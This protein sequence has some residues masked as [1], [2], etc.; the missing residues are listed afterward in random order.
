MLILRVPLTGNTN[1][2][3]GLRSAF[4]LFDNAKRVV[5]TQVILIVTDGK[6]TQGNP[7]YNANLPGAV[8][9]TLS[10]M[11]QICFSSIP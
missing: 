2:E 9:Q 8:K 1:L 11:Q 10:T 3:A 6:P 5:E 4:A 7:A